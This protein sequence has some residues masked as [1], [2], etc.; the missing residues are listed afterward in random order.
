MIETQGRWLL[1]N[2]TNANMNNHIY[3]SYIYSSL[4]QQ[5]EV[6]QL[7]LMLEEEGAD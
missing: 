1:C 4:E 6:V 2:Q 3:Y 7:F 5:I